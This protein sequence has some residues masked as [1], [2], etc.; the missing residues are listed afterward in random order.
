MFNKLL[1]GVDKALVT[2]LVILHTLVI[3]V[4]NYLV[5]IRFDL[6]PGADLPLFGSFPLAAAA[7][8]FPIV[9][10]ATDL[11]VRLVGKEAGRA[12]VAM[13]IIPAIIASVLVLLALDDPHA[14]RVGFASGTAYAIGTMLDVYVFQYIRE[15]YTD[16][17]WA[18]PA[19]ST[20]AA[21]IIDTYSFFYV[22]FAGSLD[23]EGNLSWIGANWHIVAQNNTLTKIVVGLIV[24]LP[25]Y[26]VLLAYLRNKVAI[27][28]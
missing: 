6:F 18:A 2:K 17:W 19:F 16:M 25:A 8:T 13:A 27:K 12:V 21:N 15:K 1:E 20:I 24:F 4:S 22:A 28:K 10:V 9:V 3:A 5:T 23:A 26:G 14:Y 11:T 7:F